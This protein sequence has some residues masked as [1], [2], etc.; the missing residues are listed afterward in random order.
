MLFWNPLAF[1]KTHQML[2][3]WYLVPLPFRKSSLCIWKFLVHIVLKPSLKDFE[4]NLASVLNEGN[5]GVVWTFFGI[6]LLWDWM[7]TD[8]FQSYGH[9]WVF[10]ICWH[11]ECSTFIASSFRIWNRSAGIL[12]PPLALF[13]VML[14]EAFWIQD[15]WVEGCGLIFSWENS[16][17]QQ[18]GLG[19]A[20]LN[21]FIMLEAVP[22]CLVY[23]PRVIRAGE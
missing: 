12:S 9:C 14:S 4:H 18:I 11:L 7:K 21:N 10:Q 20:G 8:L 22:S 3:I 15:G 5:C 16:R 2:A 1:S 17:I 13:V 19:L 6:A 23:G